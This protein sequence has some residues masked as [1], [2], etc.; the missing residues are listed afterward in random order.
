MADDVE[1]SSKP[2]LRQPPQQKHCRQLAP[3]F[4]MVCK[5]EMSREHDTCVES[6]LLLAICGSPHGKAKFCTSEDSH[7]NLRTLGKEPNGLKMPGAGA[8]Q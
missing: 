8:P 4:A 2:Q 3:T 6:C 1:M 5:V 7:H